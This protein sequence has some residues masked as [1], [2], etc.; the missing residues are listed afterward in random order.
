MLREMSQPDVVLRNPAIAAAVTAGEAQMQRLTDEIDALEADLHIL[1]STE[2][3][4]ARRERILGIMPL[5]TDTI[6]ERAYRV[7][8]KWYD[9]YPYTRRDLIA[10]LK[11]LVGDCEFTVNIGF[12]N[13]RTWA[14]FPGTR[15]IDFEGMT[16]YEVATMGLDQGTKTLKVLIELSSK[17]KETAIRKLIDDIAPLDL[18]LDARL[19]YRTW[20]SFPGARW[21]DFEGM[22]WYEVATIA[23]DED[24]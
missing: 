21:I 15:W 12:Q 9:T 14:S 10:R 17:K 13:I 16:W 1:T 24:E 19:R 23:A 6:Q 4:I 20:A 22:T 3:G 2:R 8:V 7:L 18:A 5:D 11:R